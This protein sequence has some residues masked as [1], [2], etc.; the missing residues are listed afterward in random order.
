MN[1]KAQPVKIGAL[2]VVLLL[3]A[4][5]PFQLA[6]WNRERWFDGVQTME[7]SEQPFEAL[8]EQSKQFTSLERLKIIANVI[9]AQTGVVTDNL[10]TIKV[11]NEENKVVKAMEGQL[12]H[13][14]EL[15]VLP[16]MQFS[17][18]YHSEFSQKTYFDLE[19][20]DQRVTVQGLYVIYDDFTVAVA[21]DVDTNVLYQVQMFSNYGSVL[22]YKHQSIDALGFF[23]YLGI[24]T[25]DVVWYGDTYQREGYYQWK[26]GDFSLVYRHE[27]LLNTVS[28]LL[29]TQYEAREYVSVDLKEAKGK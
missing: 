10:I 22:D 4:V 27:K 24:P 26:D 23:E 17:E 28:Y 19:N 21:M 7:F 13:L 2:F 12:L 5:M 3:I 1:N 14:M 8:M 29:S 20:A 6:K 18:E 11:T 15:G 9:T 16:H 25:E